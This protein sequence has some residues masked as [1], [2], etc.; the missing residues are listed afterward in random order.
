MFGSSPSK[1]LAEQRRTNRDRP[2]S[3]TL[4]PG[5]CGRHILTNLMIHTFG[6]RVAIREDSS[7][8]SRSR[9][10]KWNGF[11]RDMCRRHNKFFNE[12]RIIG[13]D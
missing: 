8:D 4:A 9:N 11:K 5:S 1:L 12:S 6:W 7:R 10:V 13:T 3:V 2:A